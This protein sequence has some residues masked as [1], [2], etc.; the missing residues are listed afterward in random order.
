[1]LN[2][3]DLRNRLE[4]TYLSTED[5][6]NYAFEIFKEFLSKR[7]VF[8]LF[9]LLS[10]L[11][12]AVISNIYVGREFNKFVQIFNETKDIDIAINSLSPN[13]KTISFLITLAAAFIIVVVIKKVGLIIENTDGIMKNEISKKEK[14]DTKIVAKFLIFNILNFIIYM[15][16]AV[17]FILILIFTGG[18]P[19]LSVIWLFLGVAFF[20]WYFFNTLY[21]EK[22]Y[23][24]RNL[25]FIDTFKYNFHLCKGNRLKYII[26]MIILI[27]F[28]WL[29][30]LP[31]GI[32][33]IFLPDSFSINV[34][35]L[36]I[37]SI[38]SNLLNF[39]QMII[40]VLITL[41]VI[42]MD[43]KNLKTEDDSDV[44]DAEIEDAEIL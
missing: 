44:A 23:F 37:S 19:A 21:L 9:F 34:L 38:F 22:L 17:P 14:I 26:P 2:F 40:L 16:L 31:F 8:V 13:L 20:I 36:T 42:Y 41:N 24:L 1:M 25:K 10:N 32:I 35:I 6:F 5:Y 43:L 39:F 11:I 33:S 18:I 15:I 12:I 30:S 29:I 7:K 3:E 28:K 27:I 4:K